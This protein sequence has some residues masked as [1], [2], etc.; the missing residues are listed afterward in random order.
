MG[1]IDEMIVDAPNVTLPRAAKKPHKNVYVCN[2]C[3]S[4]HT[5]ARGYVTHLRSERHD[6]K[7][8]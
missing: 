6:G 5:L 1:T 7:R 3:F 4:S 2:V 8:S